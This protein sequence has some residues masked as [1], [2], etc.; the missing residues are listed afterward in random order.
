MSADSSIELA[1][2]IQHNIAYYQRY[3][4]RGYCFENQTFC[5]KISDYQW[6][7]KDIFTNMHTVRNLVAFVI[8]EA[9]NLS[10][11]YLY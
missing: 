9:C 4:L 10:F 1:A 11:L 7:H 6:C 2:L 8:Q 5:R 3:T